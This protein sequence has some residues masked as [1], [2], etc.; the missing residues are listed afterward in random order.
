[1]LKRRRNEVAGNQSKSSVV[2]PESILGVASAL[3]IDVNAESDSED[4]PFDL[5]AYDEPFVDSRKSGIQAH[6]PHAGPL[7]DDAGGVGELRGSEDWCVTLT[8]PRLKR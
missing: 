2:S 5:N 1:M 6:A 4:E 8:P 7:T 3:G